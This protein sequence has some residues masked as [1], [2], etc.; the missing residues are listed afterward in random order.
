MIMNEIVIYGT[1]LI[2]EVAWFYFENDSNYSITSFC[3]QGEFIKKPS[4]LGKPVIPFEDIEKIY[5]PEH[6][7]LFVAIGYKNRNKI[8]EQRYLDGKQK[9]YKFA[10]YISSKATYYDT[11][12]GDNGF[13]LENNVI[14][15]FTVIA[16]NVTLWS[17]NHI[18]HHSTILDNSF[19]SS[20]VVIS[21]GVTIGRNCFFGVNSLVR[22]NV[23]IGNYS[24][25]G[26]GASV[27]A[28]CPENSL[29]LSARSEK[30]VAEKDVI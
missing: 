14:Q 7:L 15:P 24:V 18:G 23:A 6:F 12:V 28:D 3:N 13:I 29:V 11:P 4:F 26:A 30:R 16:N 10:T 19:V 1:G 2:A 20:H 5:P 22:D 9:G 25:I 8:R 17:G 21:G 27:M